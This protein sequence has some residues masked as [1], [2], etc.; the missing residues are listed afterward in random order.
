MAGG[1]YANKLYPPVQ[2]IVIPLPPFLVK[3]MVYL[4]SPGD[5]LL[6]LDGEVMLYLGS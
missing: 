2:V 4:E 3:Q 6:F 1:G 5:D